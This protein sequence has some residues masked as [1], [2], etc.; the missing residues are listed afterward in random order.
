[1][2]NTLL[3][4]R[5]R[6]SLIDIQRSNNQRT[7]ETIKATVFVKQNSAMNIYTRAS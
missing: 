7:F 4:N 5:K 1:M 2:V 3:A 6:E